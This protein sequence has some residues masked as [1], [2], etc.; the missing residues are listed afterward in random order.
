MSQDIVA[1]A[2]NNIM[3][4]K[5]AKKNS[6]VVTRYSKLLLNVLDIMKSK[7]YIE[8]YNLNEKEKK[9]DVK[10]GSLNECCSIKPR[11]YAN[12]GS[13]EKYIR[14]YLPAKDF[15]I[16]IVSTSKGLMTHAEA[17]EKNIGGS[18]IAYAY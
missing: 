10:I 14:R 16:V 1:D 13:M 2:L 17:A 11:F 4:A 3:N 12:V 5:R 9:L 7:G 6:V 15:G 8:G 18:L